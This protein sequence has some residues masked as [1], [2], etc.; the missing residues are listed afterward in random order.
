MKV[1]RECAVRQTVSESKNDEQM[2]VRAGIRVKFRQSLTCHHHLRQDLNGLRANWKK[3]TTTFEYQLEARK[4]PK[5]LVHEQ[6]VCELDL[7][8]CSLLTPGVRVRS[9]A[10]VCPTVRSSQAEGVVLAAPSP[11]ECVL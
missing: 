8:D 2:H 1:L 10:L 4:A 11:A 7:W 5:S 9:V 6:Q 3:S